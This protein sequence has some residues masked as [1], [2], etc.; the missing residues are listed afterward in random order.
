[1]STVQEQLDQ[2]MPF[3][4]EAVLDI[5]SL[6]PGSQALT[7]EGR[8]FTKAA[9]ELK[10]QQARRAV[11][12]KQYQDKVNEMAPIIEELVQNHHRINQIIIELA[13]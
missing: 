3:K 1:M 11:V 10:E 8:S 12:L 7:K 4:P 13:Q 9:I 5:M 6:P 2:E